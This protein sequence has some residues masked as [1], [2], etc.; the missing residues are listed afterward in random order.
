MRSIAVINK[1]LVSLDVSVACSDSWRV[2]IC[3]LLGLSW[4]LAANL[5]QARCDWSGAKGRLMQ[6]G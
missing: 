5:A 6:R 3:N 2:L 4:G 1:I